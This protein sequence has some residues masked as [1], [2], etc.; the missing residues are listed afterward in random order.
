VYI[1]YQRLIA[2]KHYTKFIS[3]IYVSSA[4][5]DRGDGRQDVLGGVC[6]RRLSYDVFKVIFRDSHARS[7]RYVL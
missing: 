6:C 7:P 3:G 5:S 4:A 2:L 1:G